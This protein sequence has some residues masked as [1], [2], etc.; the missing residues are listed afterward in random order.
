MTGGVKVLKAVDDLKRRRGRPVCTDKLAD[1]LD[2]LVIIGESVEDEPIVKIDAW[3]VG[4][5]GG[6][7]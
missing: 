1:L 4:F 6:C 3:K 5:H 7:A 2:G